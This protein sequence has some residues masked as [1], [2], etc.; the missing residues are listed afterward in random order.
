MKR[1]GTLWIIVC[2][3]FTP[4]YSQSFDSQEF[5]AYISQSKEMW[6]VPAMAVAVVKDGKILFQKG[7]GVLIRCYR[8]DKKNGSRRKAFRQ[9]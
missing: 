4:I 1:L 8:Q 9:D 7:Y 3:C 6:Q 2:F 5:D